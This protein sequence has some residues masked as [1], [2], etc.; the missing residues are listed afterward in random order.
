[1]EEEDATRPGVGSEESV[2]WEE[3]VK[4]D[5]VNKGRIGPLGEKTSSSDESSM[6]A[7]SESEPGEL[8]S[9]VVGP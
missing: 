7:S 9:V 8:E 4:R 2:V 6:S 3:A 1:M 5:D